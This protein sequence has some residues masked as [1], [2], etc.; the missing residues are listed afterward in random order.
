LRGGIIWDAVGAENTMMIAPIGRA[1]LKMDRKG[2]P[3]AITDL[4]KDRQIVDDLEGAIL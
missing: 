3:V 2:R 1:D 4:S